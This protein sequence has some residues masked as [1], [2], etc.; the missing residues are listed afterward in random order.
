MGRLGFRPCRSPDLTIRKRTF[1]ADLYL[2]LN[3]LKI[4]LPSLSQRIEDIPLFV[5]RFLHMQQRRMAF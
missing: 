1:R 4:E 2:R 5:A 3:V